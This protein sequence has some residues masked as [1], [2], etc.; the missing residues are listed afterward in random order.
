[1]AVFVARHLGHGS[2][3]AAARRHGRPVPRDGGPVGAAGHGGALPVGE[4]ARR[5]A[6]AR[7]TTSPAACCRPSS[8]GTAGACPGWS[9]GEDLAPAIRLV[10]LADNIEAFH[11]TGGVEAALDVARQRR[12]TQFDPDLVDCFCRPA[13]RDPRRAR[14]A[15]Q[16][17]DEVIALDPRLGAAL[18]RRPARPGARRR[19]AT[20]PTSSRRSASGTRAGSPTWRRTAPG[21]WACPTADVVLVRRA[22]WLHDLGMIGVPSAVWDATEPW[23]LAQRGAGPDPPVPDRAD[24]RPD[25]GAGRRRRVRGPA[26]RAPRRLGLSARAGRRRVCP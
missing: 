13:R 10:H 23:T 11:H 1:M 6:R 18:D 7:A 25:A 8:A 17:W 5:A 24:A 2:S 14:T 9:G 26:P 19:S 4:R 3:R 16:A 15:I 21:A 20:S 12:G 22:G